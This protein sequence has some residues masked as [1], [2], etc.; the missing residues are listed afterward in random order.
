MIVLRTKDR[1]TIKRLVKLAEKHNDIDLE[2][3]IVSQNSALVGGLLS[4]YR[5][6]KVKFK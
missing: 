4:K 3:I 6:E 1:Q 5:L 2:L